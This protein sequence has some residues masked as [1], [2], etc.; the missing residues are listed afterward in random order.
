MAAP[1]APENPRELP[2]TRGEKLFDALNWFGI[3]GVGI[4]LVSILGADQAQNGRLAAR[5]SKF[6]TDL[7]TKLGKPGA[8][9]SIREWAIFGILGAGG[10]LLAIPIKLLEDRKITTVQWFDRHVTKPESAQEAEQ[11]ALRHAEMATEY[12]QNWASVL[13]SRLAGFGLT[14]SSF[15]AVSERKNIFNL[16]GNQKGFPGIGKIVTDFVD[17]TAHHA[18]KV[19]TVDHLMRSAETMLDNRTNHIAHSL[20]GTELASHYTHPT[21]EDQLKS[22]L[23]LAS[24]DTIATAYAATATFIGSRILAPILGDKPVIPTK[25]V[26]YEGRIASHPQH[27]KA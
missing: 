12:K 4:Y 11:N 3:G 8:A 25:S 24:F 5:V 23:R 19:E 16:A 20:Q 6:S 15:M 13:F 14:F 21:G 7:A 17:T 27:E 10:T 22:L 1:K 18:R 9:P 26:R 2:H